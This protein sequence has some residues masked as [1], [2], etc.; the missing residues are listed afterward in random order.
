MLCK[1]CAV[2]PHAAP[3]LG[4][5]LARWVFS[6]RCIPL[7]Q[8]AFVPLWNPRQGVFAPL[9][10]RPRVFT[11][12]PDQGAIRAPLTH[13]EGFRASTTRQGLFV[14][15]TPNDQGAFVP[16]GTQTRGLSRRPG[17]TTRIKSDLHHDQHRLAYNKG[18]F[19]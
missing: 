15:P 8:G 3:I 1:P 18:N 14:P 17:P 10:P 7:D 2:R 16:L 9:D 5:G 19:P 12:E 6:P 11:L 13:D 4:A